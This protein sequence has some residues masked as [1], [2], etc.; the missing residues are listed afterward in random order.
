MFNYNNFNINEIDFNLKQTLFSVSINDDNIER[1]EFLTDKGNSYSVYFMITEE[2]DIEL[3]NGENLSKYTK[4][5][6][7][8]TIFFSLTENGLDGENFDELVNKNEQLEVM[9]K[10]VFIILEYIKTNIYT[11]YSIG[12]VGNKKINFY[13]YYK[14]YFKDFDIFIG[15]SEN[16]FDVEKGYKKAYYLIKKE[17]T[18]KNKMLKIDENLFLK[19]K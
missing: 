3:S 19:L 12:D 9:G 16:Y 7:I 4:L 18:R 2:N 8:P 13:N 5:N 17:K 10:V 6:K 11:T 15:D 14:K 1:Y